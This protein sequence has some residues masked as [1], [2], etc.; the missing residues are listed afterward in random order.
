M[1]CNRKA[2]QSFKI[3]YK[4]YLEKTDLHEPEV[5][6]EVAAVGG[7]RRAVA[8]RNRLGLRNRGQRQQLQD[9]PRI[10]G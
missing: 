1:S 8:A 2:S 9:D 7:I 5:Q 6:Q 10:A 3:R 4:F